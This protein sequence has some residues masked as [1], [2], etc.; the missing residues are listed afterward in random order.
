MGLIEPAE[1]PYRFIVRDPGR[2]ASTNQL[3]GALLD[4]KGDLVVDFSLEPFGTADGESEE[5]ADARGQHWN[6]GE[7]RVP[8]DDAEDAPERVGVLEPLGRLLIEL[9]PPGHGETVVA[10]AAIV[11]GHPPLG[12]DESFPFEAV[13]GVIQRAVLDLEALGRV[14]LEPGRDLEA[15][16]RGP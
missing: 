7:L 3:R 12:L 15:V 5:S 11:L 4:V 16:H 6:G 1:A 9:G 14:L 10:R 8:R 2:E 13:Q